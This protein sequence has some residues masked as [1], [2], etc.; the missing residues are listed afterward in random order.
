MRNLRLLITDIIVLLLQICVIISAG[1]ILFLYL[2][3][4]KLRNKPSHRLLLFLTTTDFLHATTALFYSIYLTASWD[5]TTID[6]NPYIVL[7][8]S[9]PLV[10]QLK[11]NLTLTISIA[12]ERTLALAFP[13]TYR[14]LSS[15]TYA[16]YS[17]LIG[18]LLAVL[19]LVVDFTLNP[20]DQKPNCAAIGCF[21]SKEFHYYWGSSNMAMGSIVIVLTA[22]VMTKL[23]SIQ[24]HSQ[25]AQLAPAVGKESNNFAQA[26]RTSA[27]I[28]ITSLLCVTIPSVLV[29]SIELFG[30]SIFLSVGPFYIIGLL[31][32]GFLN[33]VLYLLLNKEMRELAKS[34]LFKNCTVTT[35]SPQSTK[36]YTVTKRSTQQAEATEKLATMS[37]KTC[38]V[39][40]AGNEK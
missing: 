22:V 4:K 11:I 31:C 18:C 19:D 17:L 13:M 37:Y 29:G 10:I 33:S 3:N 15:S 23:R 7:I 9:T 2:R 35:R 6:L 26:N 40:C 39:S 14:K 27:G 16:S 38:R 30:Y 21:V 5:P 8:S 24:K 36:I 25:K 28:L 1:F 20:F 32:S 34:C 12:F